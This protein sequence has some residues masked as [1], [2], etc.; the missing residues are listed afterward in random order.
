MVIVIVSMHN[1]IIKSFN[2]IPAKLCDP[3]HVSKLC[4]YTKCMHISGV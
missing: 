4:H 3:L 2:D 1:I